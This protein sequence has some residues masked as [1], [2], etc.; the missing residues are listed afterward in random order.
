MS[1]PHG[2]VAE[3]RNQRARGEKV[4]NGLVQALVRRRGLGA[5]VATSLQLLLQ[6][7]GNLFHGVW[8]ERRPQLLAALG[9]IITPLTRNSPE[10]FHLL[11]VLQ[12]R[13][14]MNF[15]PSENCYGIAPRPQTS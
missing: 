11:S 1:R 15:E 13:V 3:C 9:K 2:L 12:E 8:V 6:L 14:W 7:L 4:S 10:G 5:F